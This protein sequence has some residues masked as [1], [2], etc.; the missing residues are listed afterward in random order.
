M[1]KMNDGMNWIP[2]SF[3]RNFVEFEI[4]DF[5]EV[6]SGSV[7]GQLKATPVK[8]DGCVH[9]ELVFDEFVNIHYELPNS[10]YCGTMLERINCIAYCSMEKVRTMFQNC[11]QLNGMV[12]FDF[13]I[14]LVG[15]MKFS[16]T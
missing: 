7:L 1:P 15:V 9:E 12:E 14:K 5:V 4:F 3:V 13:I 2:R 11:P 6:E 10:T 16:A 8:S